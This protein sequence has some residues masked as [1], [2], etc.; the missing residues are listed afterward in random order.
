MLK[1][2]DSDELTLFT[3]FKMPQHHRVSHSEPDTE[4]TDITPAI[5]SLGSLERSQQLRLF[6]PERIVHENTIRPPDSID[7]N[8]AEAGG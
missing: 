2:V 4:N 8:M 3:V 5:I 1:P 7:V 6:I